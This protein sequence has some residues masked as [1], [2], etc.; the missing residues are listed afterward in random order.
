M[1]AKNFKMEVIY[2]MHPRTQ[3]KLEGIQVPANIRIMNPL[4]F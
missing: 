3:S 2:P 4:G 1:I